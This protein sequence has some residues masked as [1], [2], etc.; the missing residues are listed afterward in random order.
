VLF[1]VLGQVHIPGDDDDLH[2]KEDLKVSPCLVARASC[3]LQLEKVQLGDIRCL[4]DFFFT[5]KI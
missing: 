1:N 4:I 3:D 2:A 5:F